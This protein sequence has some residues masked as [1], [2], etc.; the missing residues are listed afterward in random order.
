VVEI[1]IPPFLGERESTIE[2]LRRV[3]A[4]VREHPE[5]RGVL[6]ARVF[7]KH[8]SLVD[9]YGNPITAD[10]LVG[11]MLVGRTPS[12]GEFDDLDEIRK[13]RT[14]DDFV[15]TLGDFGV[16]YYTVSLTLKE[17]GRDNDNAYLIRRR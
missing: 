8:G 2:V 5:W 14:V 9:K 16:L 11:E 17:D 3:V 13:Y 6:K 7:V 15:R 12:Q 1:R 4:L 10:P